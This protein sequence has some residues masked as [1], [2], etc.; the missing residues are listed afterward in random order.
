MNDNISKGIDEVF[1]SSCGSVIKKAAEICPK[2]GV[3]QKGN[4]SD[5]WLITFLLC[6]FLG[7]LGVHRFYTGKIGT[8]ILMLITGGGCGIWALIDLI[9]ILLGNYKDSQ[10]NPITRN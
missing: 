1:C 7:V 4:A 8:G 6:L 2:C 10:G 5:N 3:R 9:M